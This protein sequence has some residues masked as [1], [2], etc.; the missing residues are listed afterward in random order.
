MERH[1]ILP[2]TEV[3]LSD[4]ET[5]EG[6]PPKQSKDDARKEL[7]RLTLRLRDLQELLYAEG[8][9]RVLVVLQAM[10]SGGK[11]G[12]I[13]HVF[14]TVNPQ[15]VKV[16][17]FKAPSSKELAHD[18]LWRIHKKVP[19]RGEIRIFNRSHYEDVLIVKVRSLAPPDV[20]ERRYG[21]ILD[22][23]RMMADEG[24]TIVKFFLHISRDEQARRF[25]ARIDNPKKRWK[26]SLQDVEERKLWD[27]YMDAFGVALSR[28]ST[29]YAPW[30][31]IPSDSKRRR[32]LS[33]ARILVDALEGLGMRYPEPEEDLASVR[34]DA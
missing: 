9:H 30:F 34:I 21:H 7:A 19:A 2:G 28:T 25:Q 3:R 32:N 4:F 16:A 33:I 12:V 18:Y 27:A 23:E 17:S 15:G 8:R 26:F 6:R 11:D 1:R 5:S 13:R 31:V 10:D 24:T 29:E 20:V 14:R 22:F